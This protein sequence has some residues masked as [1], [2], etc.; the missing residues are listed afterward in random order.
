MS[1]CLIAMFKNEAHIFKEWIDHYL[2]QGVDKF[3]LIDNGSNDNYME[4]LQY[5][6]DNHIVELVVDETKHTQ[7]EC[8]NKHFFEKSKMFEWIIVCDLDEFIY[9]RKG[10]KTIKDY[11]SCLDQN[12]SQVFIPWKIFGS[13]GYKEQ[14]ECVVKSFTKR[15]N[16]NK[17]Y[18]FQGCVKENECNYSFTKCI[19]RSKFLTRFNIH[20]HFTSNNNYITSDNKTNNIHSTQCFCKTNEDILE[21]SYLHLN[22]YSIQSFDWFMKVKATRGDAYQISSENIRDE[23]YFNAFDNVSNDI[24]DIEL[25][26]KLKNMYYYKMQSIIFPPTIELDVYK[27]YNSDLHS[28]NYTE[29]A[30]HYKV[31]GESEGRICSKVNSKNDLKSYISSESMCLEIGPFDCPVL[32]G[33]NV[34]YFDVLSQKELK[35]RAIKIN[36]LENFEKIPYIEYV[37]SVGDLSIINDTFDIVLS[38]HS[39]EHQLDFIG[40][41][42]DVSKILRPNGFYI[43]ICPDKRYCFDHFIK[44]TTVADIIEM[45]EN[46]NKKHTIKSVIEHRVLTCHNDANRH[47]NNDHGEQTI[48]HDNKSLLNAIDEYKKTEGYIDVHSL[49]FTPSSFEKNV[50]LLKKNGFI[51]LEIHRIYKTIRGSCEFYAVLQ[52]TSN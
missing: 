38:C 46:K 37:S 41:L 30:R 27:Q 21:E 48:D 3:L 11:L 20:S 45:N 40:H 24:Y 50:N 14:P 47:W 39:I 12:I 22:H 23:N 6:I 43:I 4:Y 35:E 15:I 44:E 7:L 51:D 16:Y 5:Y 42:N 34:K 31:H 1:L 18:G 10:I 33:E 13:N 52:K 9:A 49:Q 28:M 29:L 25:K 32:T 36:R 17:E 8:C 2:N 26:N 19:V